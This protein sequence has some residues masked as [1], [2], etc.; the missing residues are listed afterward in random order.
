MAAWTR[1]QLPIKQNAHETRGLLKR[2]S[3]DIIQIGQNLLDAKGKLPKG[4]FIP[5]VKTELGISQPTAWRFMQVAQGKA[6]KSFNMNELI[7]PPTERDEAK[8]KV[9]LAA[10]WEEAAEGSRLLCRLPKFTLT[11]Q[12]RDSKTL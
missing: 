10:L 5:W 12:S 6:I 2:T 3:D 7:K 1:I 8:D 4:Q 9:R 11:Q